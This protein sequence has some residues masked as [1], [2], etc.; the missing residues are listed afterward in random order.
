VHAEDAGLL[1]YLERTLWPGREPPIVVQGEL[2]LGWSSEPRLGSP[3]DPQAE[4]EGRAA[5]PE[6][7][8]GL[9]AELGLTARL[10]WP[11][12]PWLRP[13]AELE[14]RGV[15]FSSEEAWG[16]S[17]LR[18]GGR[19]GVG[20]VL[21]PQV[22]LRAAY[23]HDAL[24]LVGGDAFGEGPLWYSAG[25]TGELDLTVGGALTILAGGGHREYRPLGRSRWEA[26][27]RVGGGLPL[28]ERLFLL[29]SLSGEMNRARNPAYHLWGGTALAELDV[30]VGR[31]WSTR[32]RVSVGVDWYPDSAGGP[33]FGGDPD[34]RRDILVRPALA[35]WSPTWGGMRFA[36]A[37]EPSW[38]LSTAPA[39]E[40][41]DH[42]ALLYARWS[43]RD[44]PWR[45]AA[46][47]ADPARV[48][49][50]H[51]FAPGAGAEE[52][53]SDRIRELLRQDEEAQRASSCVD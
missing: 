51:G 43:W 5:E 52:S 45:P 30:D 3:V 46:A 10:G 44:D 23:R 29:L 48:P 14:A 16:L 6:D 34:A 1:G 8:S 47:A 2:K 11:V 9:V 21:S 35:V 15:S 22:T 39:Y 27:L 40:F 26:R 49:L 25:H 42:R 50:P 17:Y 18:P 7:A 19:V 41:V 38:Q 20:F 13:F 33:E 4:A 53:L 12:L 36:L 37:Y 32:A 24:L 28:G 31:G